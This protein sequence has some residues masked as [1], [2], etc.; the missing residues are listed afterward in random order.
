MTSSRTSTCSSSAPASPGS[1]RA[2]TCSTTGRAR[3]SRSSRRATRSAA[4]GTCSAIPGSAPTPTCSRSATRSGRG[5]GRSDLGGGRRSATTSEDTAGRPGSP[6]HIR[7]GTASCSPRGRRTTRRGPCRPA[8]GEERQ[9]WTCWPVRLHRLLRLR[10]AATSRSFP[11][12][13]DF[14][15]PI[16]HPQFWPEDLDYAGK[17]V[18][19]IGSGATASRWSRRWPTTAAHVTMLQRSPTFVIVGPAGD[20]PVADALP[21]VAGRPGRTAFLRAKNI[22]LTQGFYQLAPAPPA[23][24]KPVPAAVAHGLLDGP[25]ASSTRTSRRAYEPWDQRLCVVPTATF[26]RSAD[27]AASVV[28][29]H[30]DRFERRRHPP[31]SGQAPRGRHRRL[32][33]RAVAASRSAASS[34][35]STACRSTSARP[36]PTAA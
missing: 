23:R 21:A 18:V 20:D 36:S 26:P 6:A 13:A 4:P 16:V 28:T 7:F 11:A 1:A 15:G 33:D 10:Q 17:R 30:I 34:S 31:A 3:R 9:T 32:G 29:D 5:G 25:A 2:G 24:V 19:V 14:A 22:L 35:T 8:R 12:S 27:G